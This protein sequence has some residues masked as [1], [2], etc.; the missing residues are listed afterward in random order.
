MLLQDSQSREES[1]CFKFHPNNRHLFVTFESERLQISS[2]RDEDF[3]NCVQLYGNK[4]LTK[5]FDHG[6]P[7]SR[8]E[9]EELTRGKGIEYFRKGKPFGLF[10]LFDKTDGAFVGQMDIFP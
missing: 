2:Y 5:Y 10:S 1:F 3:E 8:K 4:T 7:R 6:K 9:I